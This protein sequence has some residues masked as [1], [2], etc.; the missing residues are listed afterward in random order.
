M[1]NVRILFLPRLDEARSSIDFSFR[2]R[3]DDH[4]E[5]SDRTEGNAFARAACFMGSMTPSPTC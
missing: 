1:T 4:N 2:S 5:K 3:K